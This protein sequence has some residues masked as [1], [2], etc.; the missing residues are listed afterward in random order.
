M[1]ACVGTIDHED[2]AHAGC[3]YSHS[4]LPGDKPPVF[5][6]GKKPPP[7]YDI[8]LER[9]ASIKDKTKDDLVRDLVV[10][11]INAKGKVPVL[12]ERCQQAGIPLQK[13]LDQL[14]AGYIDKPKAT[15]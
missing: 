14:T 8:I 1:P 5:F 15:L 3:T 13:T 2:R 10:A 11:E 9:S 12:K 4:F 6:D 7:E